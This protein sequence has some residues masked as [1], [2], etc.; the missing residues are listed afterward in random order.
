MGTGGNSQYIGF[1]LYYPHGYW[2]LSFRRN[3]PDMDYSWFLDKTGNQ[4]GNI[5][6]RYDYSTEAL[7]YITH[8][9]RLSTGLTVCSEINPLNDNSEG[10][11]GDRL[12]FA[13]NIAAKYSF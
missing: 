12:N 13:I 11:A 7:Y 8:S 2:S 9:F 3:N 6:V 10:T 4:E 1:K 5:R